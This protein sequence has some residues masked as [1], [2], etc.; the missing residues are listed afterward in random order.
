MSRIRLSKSW[1]VRALVLLVVL[2]LP[3][4]ALAYW[5]GRVWTGTT[6]VKLAQPLALTLSPGTVGVP[7]SPGASGDISMVVSNPNA[8]V[9]HVPSFVA[10]EGSP[11]TVDAGH[12]GCDVSVLSFT[13]QT[14]GGAGWNVPPAVGATDG[15][16]SVDLVG[17]LSMS[18]AAA[19]TC[20]GAQFAVP[21]DV[22][23]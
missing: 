6:S 10:D 11:I 9:I 18:E 21:L 19:N 14:N 1:R 2:A 22:G 8:N 23:P 17:S 20:Q 4:A 12:S 13:T 5:T 16:L 7:L 3:S 15:R